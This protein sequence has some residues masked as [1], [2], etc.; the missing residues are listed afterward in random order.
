MSPNPCGSRVHHSVGNILTSLR[1]C[2][3]HLVCQ[4]ACDSRSRGKSSR[5]SLTAFQQRLRESR[6]GEWTL[7]NP[8]TYRKISEPQWFTHT[9]CGHEIK[10][11][12]WDILGYR[13]GAG[14]DVDCPYCSR[15]SIL[16]CVSNSVPHFKRWVDCSTKGAVSYDGTDFPRSSDDL[17]K[18]RCNCG[19]GFLEKLRNLHR[20]EHYGC[21]P[22][23]NAS[24]RSQRAWLF[25]DARELVARRGFG[26]KNDPGSYTVRADI[27]A[28]DG[29]AAP[30]RTILALVRALPIRAHGTVAPPRAVVPLEPADQKDKRRYK[31]DDGAFAHLTPESCYWAGL[32]AADATISDAGEIVLELKA[33][34]ELVLQALASFVGFPGTCHYRTVKNVEGRGIYCSIRFRS[35]QICADLYANFGVGPRKSRNLPRPRIPDGQLAQAYMAGLFE[36]DGHVRATRRGLV[37]HFVSA[38]EQCFN[39]F[40]DQANVIT[41]V[42]AKPRALPRDEGTIFNLTYHDEAARML[43]ASLHAAHPGH[44][45]RKWK[46]LSGNR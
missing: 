42:S 17:L 28:A 6:G 3:R 30:H 4:G 5:V 29:T 34:D 37:V 46:L 15:A 10:R 1:G 16:G 14:E 8:D 2:R 41:A 35:R 18:F 12:P 25:E 7:S 21:V 19:N 38:S 27:V 23:R 24:L 32:L 22:C 43:I 39:W 36:G 9:A 20:Y 33:V 31:V 44:M 40:A 45:E 26:L 11:S 13:S